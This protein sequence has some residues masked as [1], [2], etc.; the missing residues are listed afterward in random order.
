MSSK[1][2]VRIAMVGAGQM[3]RI[4]H[5][6]ALASFDDVEFAGICDLDRAKLNEVGDQFEIEHRFENVQKMVESTSPDGIYVIAWPHY[7]YDLWVWCLQQG[8][9]LFV[10]KPLGLTQHH[11]DCLVHL[12]EVNQCITQVGLQRRTCPLLVDVHRRCLEKGSIT[13]TVCE[14]FK[15]QPGIYP[16]ATGH[17]LDNGPH[18]VDTVRWACG[19]EVVHIESRCR[20]INTPDINWV[21]AT[22]HFDNGSTG[23]I[24]FNFTSGKRIFRVQMHA[25]GILVDADPEDGAMVYTENAPDGQH[26]TTQE[27]AS[28]DK[29]IDYK[30]HRAK[31]REFI[32]SIKFGKEMTSSPFRDAHKTMTIVHSILAQDQLGR[33]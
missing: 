10:E 28:S 32:D 21:Q 17:W 24:I 16:T 25:P 26:I 22:L 4:N 27:A 11:A 9:N 15:F 20:R 1:N 29:P 12:A 30:G 31:D 7:V 23:L 14:F 13:H 6:P 3:A 8:L 33:R 5:Y 18:A 19:G 2:P